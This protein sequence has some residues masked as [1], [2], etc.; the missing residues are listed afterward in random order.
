[1]SGMIA[2]A[3][4]GGTVLGGA[5][6][7]GG[8]ALLGG[9]VGST[10]L[11]QRA[12]G[13]AASAAT[14]SAQIA[15]NADREALAYLKEINALPQDIK[16]QALT[17]LQGMYLPEGG[18]TTQDQMIAQ[19]QAS[20]LYQAIMGTRQAGEE[21]ILRNLSATGGLRS[22]NAKSALYRYNQQL[23]NEALLTSYQ[24]Q[25]R[26]VQALAGVPT[27]ESQ[28]AGTMSS[29][30]HTLAA[31]NTAEAQARQ[32]GTQNL[33]GNIMGFGELGLSAYGAG[34]FSDIRLK[35][36]IR[37]AGTRN[38]FQWYTWDWVK[39]AKVLGLT[40]SSEG[41]LAHQVFETHPHAISVR[42]GFLTVM[43]DALGIEEKSVA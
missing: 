13:Q 12:A 28:I 22:G 29:I 39:C 30:G 23:E 11:G 15:A 8:G 21:G 9:A 5:A 38:G 26:G 31:G 24:D 25:M 32:Q 20:P 37:P 14:Q 1:M 2:G 35:K 41:V 33:I 18:A 27:N 43:Y 4:V 40:G 17:G 3:V 6:A 34:L 16:E 10:I 7:I 42:D 19:A 36:N